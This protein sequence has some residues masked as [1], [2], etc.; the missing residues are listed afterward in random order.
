MSLIEDLK[1][2]KNIILIVILA[3]FLIVGSFIVNKTGILFPAVA[4]V[5][6]I[7]YL[8]T[9]DRLTDL[10]PVIGWLDTPLVIGIIIGSWILYIASPFIVIFTYI[11][12]AILGLIGL[13]Y[14]LVWIYKKV[15]RK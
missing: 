3:V 9:I 12:L 15:F 14:F 11:V 6:G 13:I 7:I 10:I 5:L 2:V 1:K 8:L 4:T